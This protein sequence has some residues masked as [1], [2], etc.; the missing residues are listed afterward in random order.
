MHADLSLR[1]RNQWLG[2]VQPLPMLVISSVALLVMG[3][4]MISSASMDMAAETM[5]NSYHYVIRQ[6]MFAG[7]GCLLALVAVNVPVAWWE[8]SGWL[9][10]GI[11]LLALVLVLTPLGRTVNGSTRWI[12]FGLFN[13]QVSE[14]AKLCLIAYL[15]GYVVR[16]RNELLNTWSGFLKP[17]VVLGLASVLLVI[18]PDFGATVVLV[19]AA[20]G[21]IFLSGVRLSRF[22]PLIGTLVVL[23]AILI[24]TQPYRLKRV[25]SYLDPWKDQFDSGYQLTQSLIAFGRGDWGGVGLG[26]SI[27]KLFYLPEAHTDFIF[28]IIAEEFGLLGSLLVLS[29]FTLLVVTGF[30]IARRAEKADMPFGA[31]FA[32]GLTLLI[33]LQAGINMAVSTGLLP[34]K[35]LTLPLVSYGGSSLMITC[36]CIGVLARV[37]MERLD[38]EKLAR[39]KTGPKTRGGAVY[40]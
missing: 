28:A 34:T 38:Q 2:E 32:Y 15:A 26:N 25:V 40:D 24:V 4:V 36:I 22:V 20:A 13:V 8:R 10:L 27:Q 14:V 3:V 31:C 7:L 9:L 12:P 23:G 21:M 1:N 6:L 35:G 16:R 33:G 11:G 37:E 17:L 19:T 39:E 18:Q 29:L 30:V 5:G